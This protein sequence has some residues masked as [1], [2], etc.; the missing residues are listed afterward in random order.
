MY[1]AAYAPIHTYKTN[2][3]EGSGG[4]QVVGSATIYCRW[5]QM[6]FHLPWSLRYQWTMTDR[7]AWESTTN[8]SLYKYSERYEWM[9]SLPARLVAITER[10]LGN[11]VLEQIWS[12][13][14]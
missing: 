12:A 7:R 9:N 3:F 10:L 4:V 8:N 13:E 1:N 2:G 5:S 6:G 14:S 11:L